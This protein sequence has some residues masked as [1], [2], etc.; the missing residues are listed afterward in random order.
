MQS[1]AG[2]S[3]ISASGAKNFSASDRRAMRASSRATCSRLPPL[4][5]RR[6]RASAS[7]PSGVPASICRVIYVPSD[8]GR[9]RGPPGYAPTSLLGYAPRR[10]SA[11][12]QSRAYRELSLV[13]SFMRV[14][15]GEGFQHRHDV[16]VIALRHRL[17]AGHPQEQVGVVDVEQVLKAVQLL[18]AQVGQMLLGEAAEEDVVFVRAHMA[19]AEQKSLARCVHDRRAPYTKGMA[20]PSW[21]PRRSAG[22]TIAARPLAFGMTGG[23]CIDYS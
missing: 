21:W 16:V 10:R 9:G 5:T 17:G 20:P 4:A 22:G 3:R 14:I 1:Q 12:T 7:A 15:Q 2:N 13:R 23:A 6:A 18:F 19:G 11:G 8:A